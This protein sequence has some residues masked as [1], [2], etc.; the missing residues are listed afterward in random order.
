MHMRRLASV[1][2]L[3]AGFT[4]SAC[5]AF[6]VPDQGDDGVER[7]N[8]GEDCEKIDD[9][10]YVAVCVSGEDQADNSSNICAADFAEI[11]CN[12]EAYKSGDH[13]LF[14]RYEEVT[15]TQGKIV[16]GQCADE[17]L[18]KR[19]CAPRPDGCDAGL[20]VIEGVC[21]DPSALYPAINP[22]Q[23]GGVEIAGQDVLDQYCRFYFCDESFVC[24][25]SG[26][27]W[28]CKACDP[29]EEF[30]QG[31]CGTLYIQGQPSTVYT[32]L[33][34]ANCNGDIPDG[35]VVFGPANEPLTP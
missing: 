30:G 4:I 10:R 16:Y 13:P 17:N 6:F 27:K 34:S 33:D 14:E 11:N 9:N 35:E 22:S 32:S 15:D 26:S 5:T 12:P 20:E 31:G 25:T 18:G 24:D 2:L 1:S 19:G 8:N 23:V 28:I 7:C 3:L 29:N 21:D